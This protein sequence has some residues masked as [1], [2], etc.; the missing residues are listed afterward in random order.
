MTSEAISR[1]RAIVGSK[2]DAY[3]DLDFVYLDKSGISS[4]LNVPEILRQKVEEFKSKWDNEP[5]CILEVE[6]GRL[7]SIF[8]VGV[9]S[10]TRDLELKNINTRP[11]GYTFS[12]IDP[13]IF[14]YASVPIVCDGV[15]YYRREEKY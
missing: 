4:C 6:S 8:Y 7:F 14:Y 15:G 12:I 10:Y 13:D 11:Y 3:K 1:L 5:Y 9:A 2:A